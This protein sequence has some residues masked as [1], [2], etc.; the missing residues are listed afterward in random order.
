MEGLKSMIN[1][2]NVKISDLKEYAKQAVDEI[3]QRAG[4]KGQF[5]NWIGVLPENQIATLDNLYDMAARAK[6]MAQQI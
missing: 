4:K 2:G 6:L 1:I 5:L 3:S